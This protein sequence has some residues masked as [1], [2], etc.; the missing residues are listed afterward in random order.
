MLNTGCFHHLDELQVQCTLL[1]FVSNVVPD[2]EQTSQM[3]YLKEAF[4]GDSELLNR[5]MGLLGILY[6]N[7]VP[8]VNEDDLSDYDG[9]N[10]YVSCNW[11]DDD[12]GDD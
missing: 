7:G 2:L 1:L 8:P 4:C 9:F 5:T 11:N 10:G 12:S 6:R 3:N